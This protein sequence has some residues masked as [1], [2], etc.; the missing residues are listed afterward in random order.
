[1]AQL[2]YATE[3]AEEEEEDDEEEGE[4][5]GYQG[6]EG[7]AGEDRGHDTR[8]YTPRGLLARMPTAGRTM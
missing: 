7:M 6:L 1:M 4:E 5:E 3:A 8:H 2:R